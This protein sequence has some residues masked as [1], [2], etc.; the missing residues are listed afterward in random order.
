M[1]R[2]EVRSRI[3]LWD[4]IKNHCTFLFVG[5]DFC[6]LFHLIT[7][8]LTLFTCA[9]VSLCGG[10][11]PCYLVLEFLRI[12]KTE[13]LC[14]DKGKDSFNKICFYAIPPHCLLHTHYRTLSVHKKKTQ[15]KLAEISQWDACTILYLFLQA[16][17]LLFSE[18]HQVV[19]YI[20]NLLL[21][22]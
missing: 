9:P 22:N 17:F 1:Y 7:F 3:V 16:P 11:L 8:P 10:F 5:L 18:P 4:F 6:L 14:D 15:L 20:F 19:T 13:W 12:S 21:I 2:T